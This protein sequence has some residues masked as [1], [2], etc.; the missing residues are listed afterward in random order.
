MC[1]VSAYQKAAAGGRVLHF[2]AQANSR[3][4]ARLLDLNLEHY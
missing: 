4:G 1:Q 2:Q 3:V